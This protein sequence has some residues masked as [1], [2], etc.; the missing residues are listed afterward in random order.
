MRSKP[1]SFDYATGS[2]FAV[3]VNG[4]PVFLLNDFRKKV[5]Q[6]VKGQKY[7]TAFKTALTKQIIDKKKQDQIRDQYGQTIVDRFR[8]VEHTEAGLTKNLLGLG[9][10]DDASE[11][12]P[13]QGQIGYSRIDQIDPWEDAAG[14][15]L[16]KY[17]PC[18]TSVCAPVQFQ[19]LDDT[20]PQWQREPASH[21]KLDFVYGYQGASCWDQDLFGPGP[22]QDNLFF[23]QRYNAQQGMMIHSG[24]IIFFAAATVVVFDVKNNIQRFF[25]HSDDVT[26]M[27]VL[28][29]MYQKPDAS[30]AEMERPQGA[31]ARAEWAKW[32]AYDQGVYVPNEKDWTPSSRLLPTSSD[33]FPQIGD[34]GKPQDWKDWDLPNR[35]I[36]ASGQ[37]GRNPRIFVWRVVRYNGEATMGKQVLATMTLGPK[38][39]Q[40]SSL[41]FNKEGN[42]LLALA[43]DSEHT[44]SVFDWRKQTKLRESKGHGGRVDC[45]KFN[46]YSDSAFASSG[47]KH[48]KFWEMGDTDLEQ[49]AGMFGDLGK[50][51]D[52]RI[53]VFTPKGNTISGV[54]NG[55]IYVWSSGTVSAKYEKAHDSEVLGIMFVDGVGLFTAGKKG[56]LKMWDPELRDTRRPMCC[57]D[58]KCLSVKGSSKL[59][60]RVSGRSMDWTTSEEV[61]KSICDD[62]Q[63]KDEPSMGRCGAPATHLSFRDLGVE[64]CLLLGTTTNSI[65]MLGIRK[66][67]SWCHDGLP[68]SHLVKGDSGNSVEGPLSEQPWW[69]SD[70]VVDSFKGKSGAKP[71]HLPVA[72]YWYQAYDEREPGYRP[73]EAGG[74]FGKCPWNYAVCGKKV[75]MRGHMSYVDAVAPMPSQRMFISASKD[76]TCRIYD[77]NEQLMMDSVYVHKPARS[78]AWWSKETKNGPVAEQSKDG[79]DVACF[80]IGHEDGSFSVYRTEQTADAAEDNEE[81]N[82]FFDPEDAFGQ[83]TLCCSNPLPR[84]VPML[85]K[86]QM[87]SEQALVI[88]FSPD[89]N[90]MAVG[91]GDNCIDIYK[92]ALV[93]FMDRPHRDEQREKAK[94]KALG[95]TDEEIERQDCFPYKRVGCCTDHSSAVGHFDFDVESGY[96]RSVSASNELLYCFVPHGKQVVNTQESSMRKWSS[97]TCTLG[98]TVKSIWAKGSTGSSINSLD[99]TTSKVPPWAQ[100]HGGNKPA[101]YPYPASYLPTGSTEPSD[102]FENNNYPG[103]GHPSSWGHHVVA[104]GDDD[105]KVKLFRWPTFGFKQAFRSY[106]GHGSQVASVRFSYDDDYLISAGGAD[107]SIFQWRHVVPN[108]VYVQNLPDKRDSSGNYKIDQWEMR[109]MLED[110][111]SGLLKCNRNQMKRSGGGGG[112]AS[113]K[114]GRGGGPQFVSGDDAFDSKLRQSVEALEGVSDAEKGKIMKTCV[115]QHQ[116]RQAATGQKGKGSDLTDIPDRL[117]VSVAVYNSGAADKDKMFPSADFGTKITDRWATITFRTKDDVDDVEELYG[118]RLALKQPGLIKQG[119]VHLYPLYREGKGIDDEIRDSSITAQGNEL[120]KETSEID[121]K[122]RERVRRRWRPLTDDDYSNDHNSNNKP[123][124]LYVTTQDPNENLLGFV[125]DEAVQMTLDQNSMMGRANPDEDEL[126]E[127]D[128]I[129]MWV[130]ENKMWAEV[131]EWLISDDKYGATYTKPDVFRNFTTWLAEKNKNKSKLK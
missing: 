100:A 27:T 55:D 59:T 115:L 78:A 124:L 102:V 35:C 7:V 13:A 41:S 23:L 46:P 54:N 17:S 28:R 48:L 98:W 29:R 88:K 9:K 121:P 86:G 5:D 14:G 65:I 99:R 67:G 15:G 92:H 130:E 112:M 60:G 10:K 16:E 19:G 93:G 131:Q 87:P 118:G 12:P 31:T 103:E 123:H 37:K 6:N 30:W 71:G 72:S 53:C 106:I 8:P 81:S 42:L 20:H 74:K 82:T 58:L 111:F 56:M 40:V 32:F 85:G 97:D 104:T 39:L 47:E 119:L 61:L 83:I 80:A 44:I 11:D 66:A 105:G 108:K 45:C 2:T 107:M 49:A 125:L 25:H 33:E 75:V 21:L 62:N 43:E 57:F 94:Q 114:S 89:G 26:S 101:P 90:Y 109:E 3:K 24:E 117:V 110:Y 91:L 52:N 128:I 1:I 96:I 122:T 70:K 113:M 18:V 77:M 38:R 50:P 22:G 36:V 63:I 84:K 73:R 127:R 68:E 116:A 34:N 4:K 69:A 64:G 79:R 51:L 129:N 76:C 126:S 95:F 120:I